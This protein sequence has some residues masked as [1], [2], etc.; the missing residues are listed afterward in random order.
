MS[1]EEGESTYEREHDQ[2]HDARSLRVSRRRNLSE[3]T[4]PHSDALH[5]LSECYEIAIFAR[6][7]AEAP[8][9]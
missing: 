1:Y 6:R 2:F 9:G 4:L 3:R 8:T 7:S 5:N